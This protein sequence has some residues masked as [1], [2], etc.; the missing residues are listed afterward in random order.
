MVLGSCARQVFEPEAPEVEVDGLRVSMVR[1]THPETKA[2]LLD[3]PGYQMETRWAAGDQV[4]LFSGGDANNVLFQVN[5][6]DI[7]YNGRSA[8]FKTESEIPAGS[9]SAYFPYQKSA[10][11]DGNGVLHLDFPAT[12]TYL[13]NKNVSAPDASAFV[14]VGQGS[15]GNGVQ[16]R[17][18][19]ALLKMGYTPKENRRL[20]RVRFR[21]LSGASVA[22]SMEVSWNAGLPSAVITGDSKEI[23]LD[24]GAEGVFLTG[25]AMATLWLVVPAR[26]YS[27]GFEMRFEFQEGEADVKT[28]GATYG[29]NILRNLVYPIGD[30]FDTQTVSSEDIEYSFKRE[31]IVVDASKND[32]IKSIDVG[33]MAYDSRNPE[34]GTVYLP[35]LNVVAHKDLGG[36]A[37]DYIFFNV[38]SE[39]LPDC[40]VGQITK[41]QMLGSQEVRL[42]IKAVEDITEPFETLVIGKP[43]YDDEGNLIEGGGVGLNLASSLQR[44]ETPDGE[45]LPFDVEGDT[46]TIYEPPTKVGGFE[47]AKIPFTSPRLK[48]KTWAKEGSNASMTAG[49]QLKLETRFCMKKDTQSDDLETMAIAMFP[50]ALFSFDLRYGVSKTFEDLNGYQEFGTFMFAPIMLGPIA[51]HPTVE[52]GGYLRAS[53]SAE[54]KLSFSYVANFGGYGLRYNKGSGFETYT[55]NTQPDPEDGFQC[56]SFG[57]SGTMGIGVGMRF[58]PWISLY[59]LA[60]FGMETDLGINFGL[61][62]ESK[63]D[64]D[65]YSN[66][67]D[68]HLMPEF[69]LKPIIRVLG[70][71]W[72]QS[73]DPYE[74]LEFDP[75]WQRY[76]VPESKV[77]EFKAIPETSHAM[78]F[79]RARTVTLS[80][81]TVDTW[82]TP[83]YPIYKFKQVNYNLELK[84][85]VLFN[86]NLGMVIY[87]MDGFDYSM[88]NIGQNAEVK[89]YLD[90]GLEDWLI[91][92]NSWSA[93]VRPGDMKFLDLVPLGQVYSGKPDGAATTLEGELE[94][95]F[96]NGKYYYVVPCVYLPA[97]PR[98]FYT[99]NGSALVICH[100][101]NDS[102]GRPLV[103]DQP[104]WE[105]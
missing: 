41:V 77:V 79:W 74:P 22:G 63:I 46:L 6:N 17:N 70:G 7:E 72:N 18:V 12:Q 86:L 69:S 33:Q 66:G 42:T 57:I 85:Q 80:D 31:P 56:P 23:V 5:E 8:V 59:G 101:P 104:D 61:G 55:P 13:R 19:M 11:L 102:K 34:N 30:I 25:E 35:T 47:R 73:M 2:L 105:D 97:F 53:A 26:N 71:L 90:N 78:W 103:F 29:K 28:V 44:I 89:W 21:D 1:E 48:L 83:F 62:Y 88:H 84:K 15:K 16:F 64:G 43:I 67:M 36:E 45:E 51:L 10:T 4:G 24:C 49:V 60:K 9:L 58:T 50:K 75:L 91:L 68:V 81:G 37:G 40:F 95:P 65:G 14:M 92:Y 3:T 100:Y 87:T 82:E 98:Q 94:Y 99:L 38:P 54:L 39:L 76:I 96:E 52:I 32:L 27:K 93:F 20:M